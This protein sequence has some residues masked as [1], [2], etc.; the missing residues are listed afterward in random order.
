MAKMRVHELAKELNIKSQEIVE[1][2]STTEFAVTSASSGI[3]DAAQE[4]VRSKFKPK[5]QKKEEKKPEKKE[6]ERTLRRINRRHRKRKKKKNR[7]GSQGRQSR[8]RNKK[9]TLQSR[10]QRSVQRKNQALLLFLMPSTAKPANRRGR[11]E[12]VETVTET[13][14]DR[15]G[16]T[17]SQD[18]KRTASSVRVRSE[19]APCVPSVSARQETVMNLP[20]AVRQITGSQPKDK[21]TAT[22]ADRGEITAAARVRSVLQGEMP[23]V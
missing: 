13:D 4:I 12:M 21:M 7:K 10:R 14:G 9:M 20:K 1:I 18:R 23:S 19:S 17:A 8:N 22:A 3:E 5:P 16:I 6:A 11:A 2:L 15:E